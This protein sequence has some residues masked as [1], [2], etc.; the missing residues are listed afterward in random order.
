MLPLID[1][2][3]VKNHPKV[4]CGFSDITAVNLA[5][6]AK[7]GLVTFNG[8][9]VLPSFG[10]FHGIDPFTLEFFLKA[11]SQKVPV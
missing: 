4:F 11:V 9:T 2:G 10:E 8:P 3:A 5:L 7:T 6:Y 1:Y